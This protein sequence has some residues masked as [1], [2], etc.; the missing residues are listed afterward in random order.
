MT[1]PNKLPC[2][3]T[4]PQPV[5]RTD[6][7]DAEAQTGV[8]GR[9]SCATLADGAVARIKHYLAMRDAQP[10]RQSA[11]I[12]HGIHSGTEWEADLLLSDLRTVVAV[13]GDAPNAE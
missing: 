2:R 13:F 1:R 9:V 8:G 12:I 4:T 6:V 5:M 3:L 7:P 11:D 10:I